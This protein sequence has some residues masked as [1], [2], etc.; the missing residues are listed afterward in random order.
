MILMQ[1][2]IREDSGNDS[3]QGNSLDVIMLMEIPGPSVPHTRSMDGADENFVNE[4][5]VLVFNVDDSDPANVT[6]TFR[7]YV[8][9]N[10]VKNYTAGQ[11]YKVELKAKLTAGDNSRVVIVT[12]ASPQIASVLSGLT[13]GTPKKTVLGQ[14]KYASS[15]WA[16]SGEGG[17]FQPIPMYGETGKV[18]IKFG[19]KFDGI[20]LRRMAARIDVINQA[21]AFTMENIF[22]CNYNTIGYI[23]P[24]WRANDGQILTPPAD[25][26][27][28]PANPGK[29][30]GARVFTPSG[31]SFIGEIYTQ[32][33]VAT[34]DADE[35]ARRNATCLVIEGMYEGE[36]SF[37]RVD[38]TYGQP[39]RYM[40]L[41]RNYKYEVRIISAAG[42]GY[43]TF[44]EALE[45]YTVPSNLMTRTLHYDMGIITDI[46]FDGQY[47]LGVSESTLSWEYPL[48]Q[49]TH[50]VSVFTDYAR[51]WEVVKIE[52][53]ADGN[54]ASWVTPSTMTGPGG[55]VT[56]LCLF[57]DKNMSGSGRSACIYL[58]AGRLTHKF[59]I[60]Q[61][62]APPV[63]E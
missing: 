10:V 30:P 36:K 8:H 50:R 3:T 23:A 33:A 42:R 31:Q 16:A 53:A 12:N 27:N 44:T 48:L 38:F 29:Q 25:L 41:L 60:F 20:Q 14:L 24:G 19:A 35:Q 6:E 43:D 62:P 39:V 4:V 7:E 63:A 28:L 47:M 22:L 15:P 1:G 5:E 46:E 55:A 11:A 40:P 59:C 45:S 58:K 61:W 34:N 56:D 2:C 17:T 37:Y 21:A 9:G 54:P 32:E 13:A 51:G 52:D 57:L 26:P 18:N 49:E